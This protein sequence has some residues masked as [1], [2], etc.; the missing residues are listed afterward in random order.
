MLNLLELVSCDGGGG[1]GQCNEF[2]LSGVNGTGAKVG[3]RLARPLYRELRSGESMKGGMLPR[4]ADLPIRGSVSGGLSCCLV[5][6]LSLGSS[7]SGISSSTISVD[8]SEIVASSSSSR[9][10]GTGFV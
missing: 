6:V 3:V 4:F 2:L 7:S 8:A 9:A 5:G 10:A 1:S